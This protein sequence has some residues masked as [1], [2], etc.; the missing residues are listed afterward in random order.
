MST[1]L[2]TRLTLLLAASL[3]V[4][5]C[6]KPAAPVTQTPAPPLL[7]DWSGIWVVDGPAGKAPVSGYPEG[8]PLQVWSFI[9]ASAPLKGDALAIRA[10]LLTVRSL[11]EAVKAA[12]DYMRKVALDKAVGWGF[13]QMMESPAPM[14]FYVTPSETLV[15]N[16]YRD[17]RHIYTDGRPKPPDDDLWVTPW[18]YS[19]GR[20]EGDTLV[21]ETVLSDPD[22]GPLN[23]F[24]LT[25]ASSYVERIRK[26]GPD[27]IES[28]MT[29]T[30][31]NTL[32]GPWKLHFVYRRAEGLDRLFHADF[33]NDRTGVEGDSL[34]LEAPKRR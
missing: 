21:V 15:L 6:T 12:P 16:Y 18:G 1:T 20:W 30:D 26:T 34:T 31:A 3:F 5:A 32:E 17:V 23:S 9:G 28:E 7:P 11:E 24:A 19:S 14:Q 22:F 25:T 33:E 10:R 8:P 4:A 29:I 13:P 2:T 27:R